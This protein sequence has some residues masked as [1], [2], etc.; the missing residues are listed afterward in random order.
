MGDRYIQNTE[1]IRKSND[2]D[3]LFEEYDMLRD[4]EAQFKFLGRWVP[5]R[6]ND[7]VNACRWR[8]IELTLP[9]YGLTP[10]DV[11]ASPKPPTRGI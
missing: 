1:D 3:S 4:L 7:R 9:Y 8:I 2:I 5:D 10:E 6:Y 11:K